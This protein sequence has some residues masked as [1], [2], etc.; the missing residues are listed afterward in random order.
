MNTKLITGGLEEIALFQAHYESLLAACDAHGTMV[1]QE[2]LIE[3]H[4]PENGQDPI[5][6]FGRGMREYVF[7]RQDAALAEDDSTPAGHVWE[8]GL[9]RESQRFAIDETLVEG[10]LRIEYEDAGRIPSLAIC[11]VLG[12]SRLPNEI[13]RKIEEIF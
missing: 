11:D 4:E 1:L 3:E 13:I 2:R 10:R 6:R 7:P 5:Y 8:H 12:D 9:R